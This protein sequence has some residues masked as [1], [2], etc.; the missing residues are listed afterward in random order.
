MGGG[1]LRSASV[2]EYLR[3]RYDVDVI[4][5]RQPHEPVPACPGA[6]DTCVIDL[7]AH[8]RHPLS[9][10]ARN[11]RRAFDGAPP[12]IDRFSGFEARIAGFVH[13]KRYAVSVIEHFWCASYQPQLAPVSGLTVINLHNIESEWHR[14]CS[15]QAPWYAQGLLRRFARSAGRLERAGLPRFSLALTASRQ[16][17]G[18]VARIAPGLKTVVYPNTLP[19]VPRPAGGGDDAIVFPGN[20]EYLPNVQA[21]RFFHRRVWPRLR[22]RYPALVWR[23]VGKNP[24]AVSKFLKPDANIELTGPVDD[25][26]AVIAQAKV[27]VSPVLSGSGTRLKILEM[28]AAGLPVVS[29]SLGAEGLGAGDG[30]HYLRADSAEEFADRITELLESPE[31]RRELGDAGRREYEDRFTWQAG[32]RKLEEAGI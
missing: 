26:V 30:Q 18:R 1:A 17:A 5:F 32:W 21:V 19:L 3:S 15:E 16:D 4:L 7:P 29:T 20:L 27:G 8:G 13:G 12:L 2:Y 6:C 31:R 23:L 14:S 28:W 9:R 25:A 24:Q 11:L 22:D 10:A